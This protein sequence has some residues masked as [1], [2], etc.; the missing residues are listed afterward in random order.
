MAFSDYPHR[1]V[2]FTHQRVYESHLSLQAGRTVRAELSRV[3]LDNVGRRDDRGAGYTGESSKR[4]SSELH[5]ERT[6]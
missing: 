3:A 2:H 6:D 1:L 5:S 4:R